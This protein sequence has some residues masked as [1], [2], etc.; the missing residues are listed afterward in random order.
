M[1]L[2]DAGMTSHAVRSHLTGL[3]TGGPRG[4]RINTDSP[5]QPGQQ[6]FDLALFSSIC[7]SWISCPRRP[8]VYC[9][10][11]QALKCALADWRT[12]WP[13]EELQREA[14][15]SQQRVT[16]TELDLLWWRSRAISSGIPSLTRMNLEFKQGKIN[17]GSL[18]FIFTILHIL[19]LVVHC[20]EDV[21][22]GQTAETELAPE[23]RISPRL[24]EATRS[25]APSA[26]PV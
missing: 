1:S 22:T 18:I 20:L 10:Q 6:V 15:I 21:Q 25:Q 24:S 2:V 17:V 19:W 14:I 7:L 3:E 23:K 16:I 8:S 9:A 12:C 5:S 4:A 26:A 11:R 13:M